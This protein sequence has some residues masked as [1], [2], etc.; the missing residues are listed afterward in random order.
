MSEQLILTNVAAFDQAE[1]DKYFRKTIALIGEKKKLEEKIADYDSL[2]EEIL[3]SLNHGPDN[4][5][6]HQAID[7]FNQKWYGGK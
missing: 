1:A 3:S 4:E 2:V 7:I 6:V 5:L